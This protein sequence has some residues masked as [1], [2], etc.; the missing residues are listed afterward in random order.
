[1]LNQNINYTSVLA[2]LRSRR[3]RLNHAIAAIEQIIGETESREL[4]NAEDPGPPRANY[5][6]MTIGDAALHFLGEKGRPQSTGAIVT[7]LKAGNI[8]SKS[9]NLYTTAYNTLTDRARRENSPLVRVGT[10]WGL[11]IWE[12]EN[13]PQGQ[14]G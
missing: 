12:R 2:D 13:L 5:R 11:A 6:R 10:D 3:D 7:A 1:M 8:S 9:K 14:H 4:S